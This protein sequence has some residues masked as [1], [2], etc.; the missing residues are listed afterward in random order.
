VKPKVL[1]L[2]DSVLPPGGVQT[3][4]TT[5]IQILCDL[6]G[7]GRLDCDCLVRRGAIPDGLPCRTAKDLGIVMQAKV[8]CAWLLQGTNLVF[9]DHLFTARFASRVRAKHIFW[10]HLIEFDAP[11]QPI[12][13][14]SIASSHQIICD[15][16]FTCDY[17]AKLYPAIQPKLRV[18]HLGDSPRPSVPVPLYETNSPEQR[19]TMI[20]RMAPEERYKGHDQVI[21]ALPSILKQFPSCQITMI[22]R[23]P[24]RPRLQKKAKQLN[25]MN[26]VHFMGDVEDEKLF[27]VIKSSC[28]ILLP[29]LREAFGIVYLYAMWAGIPAVAIRGTAGEEIL[30]ECGVYAESQ[31]PDAINEA[32]CT[33]LSGSWRFSHTSQLRYHKLFSYAAFK[34]RL[35]G[36]L[37]ELLY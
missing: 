19:L 26:H 28:G 1:Y 22:G 25:L 11:L 34:N 7:E 13:Q 16:H 31:T 9:S 20:G 2:A 8:A 23:G 37:A 27:E 18:V 5:C 12:H 21:E 36:L 17:I 14:R 15:A 32:V 10:A 35:A 30:A 3:L 24:D 4:S 33:I 6:Q 29:S